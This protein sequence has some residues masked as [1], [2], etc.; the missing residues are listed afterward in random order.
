MARAGCTGTLLVSRA[1]R[2]GSSL[3]CT[4]ELGVEEMRSLAC[5]ALAG[6]GASCVCAIG[7]AAVVDNS[8]RRGCLARAWEIGAVLGVA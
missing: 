6:R 3:R 2:P 5:A 1:C 8:G 4:L 7:S